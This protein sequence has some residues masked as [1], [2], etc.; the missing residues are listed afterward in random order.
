MIRR[1]VLLGFLA[2]GVLGC[3]GVRGG[4]Q[5][6]RGSVMNVKQM[7]LWELVAALEQQMPVTISRVEGVTG[8]KFAL[9]KEGP[10][11]VTLEAPGVQLRDGL[12]VTQL[13]MM[14]RP[15]LQFE[16]NSGMSLELD[17]QCITLPQV[18]ERFG[19]LQLIQAPRGRSLDETGV[20]AV[21]RPWGQLSFAFQERR[22]DCLFR[23]SFHKTPV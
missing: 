14:L 6:E 7:S 16:D 13:R 23:V 22:P 10:A 18:R 8:S 4:Q 3:A 19:E 11:Y 5:A 2:L 21:A 1:H 20:W 9:V 15:S 17:G 12:S